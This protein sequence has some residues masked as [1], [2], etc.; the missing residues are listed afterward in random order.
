MKQFGRIFRFELRGYLTNKV[1]VGVT[2]LIM[3]VVAFITF[4]PRF[5]GDKDENKPDGA[6]DKK[7]MIVSVHDDSVSDVMINSF[8]AAFADYDVQ[9]GSGDVESIKKQ[10]KD[11]KAE[12]AFVFDTITTYKYYVNNLTMSD[13]NMASANELVR[14]VY[15]ILAMI[16]GG[17][18][19]V[20]A[21]EI[22]NVMIEG[23]SVSLGQDQINNFFYT[24]IMIMALYIVIVLYG[25]MIS[26]SVAAEKSSRAMELLITSAKP[27]NMMFG[28]VFAACL[29]GFLQL[30]L[31]FG[32]AYVFY[33]INKSYMEDMKFINTAFD[34]P[35][36]LL[37][38]MLV[39]FVL[40][41]LV[42]AT[43][44][45]AVGSTVSKTEDLNTASMPVTF[46]FVIGFMI[47]IMAISGSTVDSPLMKVCSFIPFT[48]PMVMFARIAMSTVPVTEI[49]V[50]IA[51][52][53][54]SVFVIGVFSARIYRVGVLMY[55]SVL[56]PADILK[57]AKKQ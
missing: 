8:K 11:E 46:L 26:T 7:V 5:S 47:V 57:L 12:C 31:I 56:K 49:A 36:E 48:S 20:E 45:G 21:Q 41:F 3:L 6:D 50:S 29:A 28:K 35:L 53:V 38:Y 39:F 27:V 42:Y 2:A 43:M 32:S 24:Y 9:L 13:T 10:I 14:G 4:I 25:Q 30:A 44:Y 52:L 22:M 15:Q 51:V 54:I 40:G 37:I 34:I 55:G 19:E 18:P 17:I 23:E 16:E 1:F 33:N